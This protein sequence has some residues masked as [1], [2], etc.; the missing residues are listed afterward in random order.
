MKDYF[1]RLL[2]YDQY[3][4]QVILKTIRESNNP[5]QPIRLM[6]HLLAAQ[7]RWLSRCKNEPVLQNELWPLKETVPF[8][9]LIIKQSGEWLAYLNTLT[10]ADFDTEI[11]YKNSLGTAYSDKLVDI[12]A[13]LINH[14]T[15]HRAQIGQLL[16]HVGIK[17]LP[18]T[19]YITYIR[20]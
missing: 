3:A 8:D 18:N 13:H 2:E 20:N 4:N 14:G 10:P 16:K 12:L 6:G 11:H 5:E 19:D 17:S 1:I 9:D 7:E 15:H